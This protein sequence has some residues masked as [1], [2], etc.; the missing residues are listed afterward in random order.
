MLFGVFVA[1][2]AERPKYEVKV[3]TYSDC[4]WWYYR[5]Y[6]YKKVGG[7]EWKL[8]KVGWT[9][10]RYGSWSSPDHEVVG[11]FDDNMDWYDPEF[12]VR[13]QPTFH[14]GAIPEPGY[15]K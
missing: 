13:V 14:V 7:G 3:K 9:V 5:P 12:G 8:V 1:S 11:P 15:C 4:T 10:G 6:L 2:A